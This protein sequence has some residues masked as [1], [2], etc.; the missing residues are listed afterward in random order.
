MTRRLVMSRAAAIAMV[1]AVGA[2]GGGLLAPAASASST[3]PTTP[4]DKVLVIAAPHLTWAEVRALRPPNLMRLFR[5]SSIA[6]LSVRTATSH[7]TL[8]AGYL[9]LGAGNRSATDPT[10]DGWVVERDEMLAEGNPSVIYRRTTGVRPTEPILALGLP[11]IDAAND[12]EHFG[13]EPGSLAT[14]LRR[15]HRRVGVVANAD[16]A[17]DE[18]MYRQAGLMAI[19]INGQVAEGSVRRG[20]LEPDQLA[21]FGVRL[22][23]DAVVDAFDTTWSHSAVTVVEMSDLARAEAARPNE[24]AEQEARQFA[25]AV[26]H[27]DAIIGRILART[28]A[29]TRVM[30]VA[31]AAPV[32]AEQITVFSIA[33]PNDAVGGV[34]TS[35]T[36]RRAG[37]VTLTDVAPTIL[38]Q[39]NVPVP[40]AMSDTL[41]S[42]EASSQPLNQRIDQLVDD[43]N[44]SLV[45]DDAFGTITV[46]FVVL[47]VVDLILGMLYLARW[48][49]LGTTVQILSLVVLWIPPLT[50]LQGLLPIGRMTATWLG[51]TLF[52]GAIVAALVTWWFGRRGRLSLP[53]YPLLVT[54]VVLAVDIVTGAHLQ[55]NTVFGYSPIVAGRFAGYGNQAYSILAICTLLL[56]TSA[57]DLLGGESERPRWFFPAMIVLLGAT[58]VLDGLPAFGSDVGGVLAL[59]PAGAICLLVLARIRIRPRLVLGIVAGTLAVISVF[60]LVD[61]ARPPAERTHLG[62]F[63]SKLFSGDGAQIIQRKIEANLSVLNTVWA[64]VI[65]FALLYFAY[66]TWR[67][68]ATFAALIR[69][70]KGLR[71]FGIGGLVL[72]VLSMLLNDSGVSM[73][74]MMLAISLAYVTFFTIGLETSAEPP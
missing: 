30:V 74:A 46:I 26:R 52:A 25:R 23:S 21:P 4:V 64:W 58:V 17:E 62:R 54:W 49:S 57:W 55:I 65:P 69:R 10:V 63:V 53:W 66:L 72:G 24:T 48:R 56:I 31:P 45:R 32:A 7:T 13:A 36:T 35:S 28:D 14:A 15:V 3:K 43:S 2:V 6:S 44:R 20:L 47:L 12:A 18:P 39:W 9:S 51:A 59:V 67:P 70:H 5:R 42:T 16:Q 61:L 33:G 68:N 19:D 22:S 8:G 41:I 60:A 38:G 34:A 27:D 1:L 50:F 40:D 73:P 11:Q 71:A 29:H 37:Y